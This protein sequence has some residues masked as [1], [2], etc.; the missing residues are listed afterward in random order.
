[1]CCTDFAEV[2][3]DVLGASEAPPY[4]AEDEEYR[5]TILEGSPIYTNWFNVTATDPDPS[6]NHY[7]INCDLINLLVI[8]YII[9]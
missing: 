1:M 5:F 8:D 6:K 7:L 2:L 9:D 4:F 3:I